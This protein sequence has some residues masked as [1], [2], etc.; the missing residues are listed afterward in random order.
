MINN[1]TK[2]L[3]LKLITDGIIG[4]N[5]IVVGFTM[6]RKRK[7]NVKEKQLKYQYQISTKIKLTT[8]III[9]IIIITHNNYDCSQV[10][11]H[12]II[13]N[14]EHECCSK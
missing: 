1:S 8:M 11:S 13:S 7:N 6:R 2:V 4:K 5:R 3:R 10:K 9:I 12:R 14:D